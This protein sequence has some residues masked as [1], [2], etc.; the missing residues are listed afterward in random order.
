MTDSK[1]IMLGFRIDREELEYSASPASRIRKCLD[2]AYNN[3]KHSILD[4]DDWDLYIIEV[5]IKK[6]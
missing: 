4:G 6:E 2:S 3:I 5:R 1:D